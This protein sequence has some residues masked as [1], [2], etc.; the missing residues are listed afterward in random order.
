MQAILVD[1]KIGKVLSGGG[2]WPKV[3]WR[4]NLVTSQYTHH[5]SLGKV[6]RKVTLPPLKLGGSQIKG[7]PLIFLLCFLRLTLLKEITS[8]SCA[9]SVTTLRVLD[10]TQQTA[11]SAIAK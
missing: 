2:R 7:L 10:K 4:T 9:I 5:H 11:R 8:S 3:C 1:C 6:K